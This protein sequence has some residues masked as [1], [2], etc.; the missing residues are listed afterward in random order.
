MLYGIFVVFIILLII[1]GLWLAW[2]QLNIMLWITA[3]SSRVPVSFWGL[4]GM[5]IRGVPSEII[6]NN[7]IRAYKA[8]FKVTM[9]ELENHYQAKGDLGKVI[10]G[11]I[12]AKNAGILLDF[13]QVRQ[14]D[15]SGRD[16][17]K[18]VG[19]VITARSGGLTLDLG[20]ASKIDLSGRDVEK[21]VR[22]VVTAQ[23]AGIDLP[24]STAVQIDLSGRDISKVLGSV[25]QAKNAGIN[26]D[27]EKAIQI[28]LSGRDLQKVINAIISAQNAGLDVD[29]DMAVQIDLAGRDIAEAVKNAIQTKIIESPPERPIK[30]LPR[31][32]VEVKFQA[33]IT[34]KTNLNELLAGAG[35]DDTI[36]SRIEQK[37]VSNISS[38]NSYQEVLQNPTEVSNILEPEDGKK[39]II[40]AQ[41]YMEDASKKWEELM[42][43][44]DQIKRTKEGLMKY[45]KEEEHKK[46][47]IR[48]LK[49]KDKDLI[50]KI[51]ELLET[52]DENTE[53]QNIDRKN[54]PESELRFLEQER[55]KLELEISR[56]GMD[57]RH[58][59]EM[60][61]DILN[62]I[63]DWEEERERL[64]DETTRLIDYCMKECTFAYSEIHESYEELKSCYGEL[65]ETYKEVDKAY[66]QIFKL[67][68]KTD[69]F[70]KG[71]SVAN[72]EME[73]SRQKLNEA[74]KLIENA[75]SIN[76]AIK[77]NLD[78]VFK[79]S[80]NTKTVSETLTIKLKGLM[81]ILKKEDESR[82]ELSDLRMGL[83]GSN[84]DLEAAYKTLHTISRRNNL[85]YNELEIARKK[86][87]Q[88]HR[89]L[90]S[91]RKELEENTIYH[92]ISVEI[93]NVEIGKDRGAELEMEQ[94]RADEER[95]KQHALVRELELNLKEKE[96]QIRELD[97][98][99]KMMEAEAK[100]N[101]ALAEAFKA[102]N[103]GALDYYKLRNLQSDT[104]MRNMLSAE[105]EGEHRK[106][107]LMNPKNDNK[108]RH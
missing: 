97:A 61:H 42:Q 1:G 57:V 105:P 100:V 85:S 5:K 74:E 45:N 18:V 51:N 53:N 75:V 73:E 64:E 30:A 63:K 35:S 101:E 26:L 16:V 90:N 28:D 24:I 49:E 70:Q 55:K 44:E 11:L 104:N 13:N 46:E 17:A 99:H 23:N 98:K 43:K 8:G 20:T 19:A 103:L 25:I 36:I 96:A 22:A 60:Q 81:N 86:M 48:L 34:V 39:R 32:G 69:F 33:S 89:N 7:M 102:G 40:L 87:T 94:L 14:I 93:K 41:K 79:E 6:I 92:V 52:A 88:V 47:E 106:S 78:L 66:L 15:L 72:R 29:L 107:S 65:R 59:A 38:L 80:D 56:L 4:I 31:D 2:T 62:Q 3:V 108:P 27:L 82:S 76:Q 10:G 50:H 84:K 91:A 77:D 54:I 67:P 83:E 37:L 58:I 71:I 95:K 21:I 68:T 9:N 12:T